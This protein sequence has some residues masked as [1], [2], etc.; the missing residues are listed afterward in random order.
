MLS[1]IQAYGFTIL[2][3]LFVW[4]FMNAIRGVN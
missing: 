4:G 3:I 2:I 1:G